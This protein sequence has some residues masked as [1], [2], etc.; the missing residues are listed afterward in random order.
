MFLCIT[1]NFK[2]SIGLILVAYGV[3]LLLD[4]A[5]VVIQIARSWELVDDSVD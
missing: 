4:S 5:A 2:S 3:F 1:E